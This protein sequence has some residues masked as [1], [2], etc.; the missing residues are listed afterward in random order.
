[1]KI[2]ERD[3]FKLLAKHLDELPAGFPPTES[4][5][6]LRILRRLFTEEEAEMALHLTLI[7]ERAKSIAKRTGLSAENACELL[8]DMSLKGLIYRIDREGEEPKYMAAHFII[9]IWEFHVNDLSPELIEDMEEYMPYFVSEI[10]EK[11]PQLRTVP[12]NQSIPVEHEILDYE[13]AEHLVRSHKKFLVAPCICRRERK[14]IGEG[15][16]KLEEACLVLGGGVEYYEKNGLGRRISLDETLAILKRADQEG[17]VVQPSNSQSI[18]NICLCCGCCCGILRNLK[19]HP[20]PAKI[21]S[22]PFFVSH[23]PEN[24]TVCEVCLSRCPMDALSLD[25]EQIVVDQMLCIGCGLCVST[26]PSESMMLVR[27]PESEQ[28]D[29]P[30][31]F[32]EIYIRLAKQRGKL[33]L[34]QLAKHLIRSKLT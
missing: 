8:S 28:H 3:V 5:V 23:D 24:C 12:I 18:A 7:P 27:K 20:E 17:L 29:V 31:K 6:E 34:T 22:S 16:D 11:T 1:M 13:N 15:C 26:C 14:M 2:K 25:D 32:R 9:G 4:G 19:R 21:V 30:K 10:W 33:K